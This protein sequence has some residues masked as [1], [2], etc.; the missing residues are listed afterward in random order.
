MAAMEMLH[1]CY[2]SI[3]RVG[4]CDEGRVVANTDRDVGSMVC[5]HDAS[6]DGLL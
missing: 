6:E 5:G 3:V 2:L 4:A 1:F